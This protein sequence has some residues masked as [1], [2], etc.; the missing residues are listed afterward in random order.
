MIVLYIHMQEF[1]HL[2]REVSAWVTSISFSHFN[3][4]KQ[5]YDFSSAL[6][7]A[8]G[9]GLNTCMNTKLACRLSNP[10]CNMMSSTLHSILHVT[11]ELV[12]Y[13]SLT[14][15]FFSAMTCHVLTNQS[16][17]FSKVWQRQ[18]SQCNTACLVL[19]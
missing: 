12:V 10:E 8:L 7:A 15:E 6:G 16:T 17:N 3:V 14:A 5:F 1:K 13:L 19:K 18:A 11:L 4:E 2:W 9:T